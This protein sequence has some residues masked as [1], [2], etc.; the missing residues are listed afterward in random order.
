MVDYFSIRRRLLRYRSYLM[1]NTLYMYFVDIYRFNQ[2][3]IVIKIR[4]LINTNSISDYTHLC[5]M[6][7]L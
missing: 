1:C 7:L 5:I 3:K 4:I 6:L 2:L